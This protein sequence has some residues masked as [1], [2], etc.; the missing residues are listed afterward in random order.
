MHDGSRFSLVGD[1]RLPTDKVF[2]YQDFGTG[3]FTYR[4]KAEKQ[5]EINGKPARL[6]VLEIQSAELQ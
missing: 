3:R 4:V 5:I 1:K 6:Y 2:A